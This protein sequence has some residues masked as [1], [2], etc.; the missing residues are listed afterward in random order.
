MAT[1]IS[2]LDELLDGGLL[3][4]RSTLIKGPPGSGKTTFGLQMLVSGA[5]DYDE[6]GIIL[7][8]ELMP[9]QLVAD[10]AALGWDLNSIAKDG[11][12]KAFFVK[13]S[14]ILEEPGR[15]EHE[16]LAKIS[17]WAKLTNAKRL[18]IDSIS[19]IRPLYTGDD[20]RA[21][22]MDFI[23]KLK[24]L[25]LTPIM[26]AERGAGDG[27]TETDT[28]LTDNV[29][30]VDYHN[31]GVGQP[32][33]RE[34]EI[35]K[36]RGHGHIAG[37]HPFEMGRGGIIV[38]PHSYPVAAESTAATKAESSPEPLPTGIAKLDDLLSGGYTAGSSILVAGLSGTYKTTLAAHFLAA[39]CST[40]KPGIW[41]TFQESATDLQ[42]TF[43]SRGVDLKKAQEEG[44]IH[45]LECTPGR[46]TIEKTL[47]TTEALIESTGARCVV[48]DSMNE[49]LSA[50]SGEEERREAVL[51]I[52]RRLRAK[53]QTVLFT[54]ALA[55]VTGRN[56]LSEI[57]W[58][59]LADT[60]VYL[61][62]VEIESRLEKVISV[63]KHRGGTTSGDLRSISAGP[64]GLQVSE[65]FV[66][67][68]G[69]LG[70]SAEGQRK[71]QIETI[72]QPLYFMRDFL[73][74]AKDPSLAPEKREGV[75][76]NLSSQTQKL[77]EVLS[78]YFD[79]PAKGQDSDK[80][81]KEES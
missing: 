1:G 39:A 72:F 79:Q 17:D 75:L 26:T 42:D 14:D 27:R 46:E 8:F 59:D 12:L 61:G 10:G 30:L 69:V 53:G 70:G 71:T 73:T 51:W 54:Q 67:L 21:I 50:H 47:S 80:G 32:D 58:A 20:S 24:D 34:V 35:V 18:L 3:R 77:I 57:D 81:E 40:E 76:N 11:K 44:S 37:A 64:E 56:P 23:I 78:E 16:L 45:V 68:S 9:A 36:T 38:Y 33:R 49:L 2:G 31:A 13:T 74:L 28:Y 48:I 7:T 41:L 52:L 25:G 55:K 43:A 60:I 29:I 62:L 22:F 5:V 65:R 4:G 63:L 66:G 19:H 6:P 15:Q